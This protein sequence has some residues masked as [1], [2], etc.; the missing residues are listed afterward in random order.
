V[1]EVVDLNVSNLQLEHP[2]QV[3]LYG[4]GQKTRF[5]PLWTQTGQV[6]KEFLLQAGLTKQPDGAV[7]P[8]LPRRTTY[9][10]WSKIHTCEVLAKGRRNTAN[11]FSKTAP[12]P[13]HAP[14]L[15]NA[16]P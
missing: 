1:Q 14:Q 7:F 9:S 4:K 6:L 15:L 5:C 8:Q 13:Q 3:K 11:T 16:S 10:V 2:F 12:S